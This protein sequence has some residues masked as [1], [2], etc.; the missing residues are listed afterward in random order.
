MKTTVFRFCIVLCT[1]TVAV[2]VPKLGPVIALF[3]ALFGGTI[4][5]I[6]PPALYL[7]SNIQLVRFS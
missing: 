7:L 6:L 3:G 1:F 2:L 5:L 4:E